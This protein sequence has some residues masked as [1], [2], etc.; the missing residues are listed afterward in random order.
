MRKRALVVVAGDPGATTGLVA[1]K[2]T[3]FAGDGSP[4]WE[5]AEWLGHAAVSRP[6]ETKTRITSADR[7]RD[8]VVKLLG[9][10][11]KLTHN[12]IYGRWLRLPPA[13]VVLEEPFDGASFYNAQG[14]EG[15]HQSTG[16]SFR[17]GVAY[18][19][20][21]SAIQY[22]GHPPKELYSYPCRT[23]RDRPGWM[24]RTTRDRELESSRIVYRALTGLSADA[25]KDEHWL[26]AL[27]VLRYWA[28]SA[29][30][31]GAANHATYTG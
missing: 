6:G 19:A 18:G 8:F 20:L 24:A 25:K 16:T 26:M 10:I 17:L 5:G 30:G 21:V 15:R 23:V 31:V 11:S 27:G 9:V 1:V 13:I 28:D 14:Q 4:R 12:L 22:S 7:D 29:D 2:F 3:S